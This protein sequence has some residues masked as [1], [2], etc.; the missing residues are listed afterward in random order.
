[1]FSASEVAFCTES[2]QHGLRL[3]GRSCS[4]FR[5]FELELGLIA[6]AS[7]S[8]RLHV[9][10][11]DVIVGVKVGAGCLQQGWA[12]AHGLMGAAASAHA[13]THARTRAHTRARTHARAH[14][15]THTCTHART[16]ARTRAR[17]HARMHMRA[18]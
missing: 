2:I 10:S 4:D 14:A 11:T 9:G 13:C 15:H 8:A 5:P 3:D 16:R 12:R 6:Q 1:M 18:R 7:G 17:T